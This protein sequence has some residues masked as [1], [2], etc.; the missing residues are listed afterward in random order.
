MNEDTFL[1]N[2]PVAMP[3]DDQLY[4]W[5]ETNQSWDAVA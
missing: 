5:N 2:A 1:W 3:T 4:T